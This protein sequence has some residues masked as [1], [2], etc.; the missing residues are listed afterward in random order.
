MK[1]KSDFEKLLGIVGV[2]FVLVLSA[3]AAFIQLVK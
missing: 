2:A 1:N 3:I